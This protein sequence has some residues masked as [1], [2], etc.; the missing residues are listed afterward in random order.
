MGVEFCS[1][2]AEGNTSHGYCDRKEW[3]KPFLWFKYIGKFMLELSPKIA[4]NQRKH[5][6]LSVCPV[7]PRKEN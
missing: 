5:F 3:P 6:S 7:C 2:L 4:R 1:T